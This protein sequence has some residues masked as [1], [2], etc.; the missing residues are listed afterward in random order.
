MNVL[1]SLPPMVSV[2]RS[3]SL[4]NASNCGAALGY[5][6]VVKSLVWAPPQV[7]SVSCV[8]REAARRCG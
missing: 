5:C 2:T 7:T 3:V 8:P 6:A 1:L 4:F